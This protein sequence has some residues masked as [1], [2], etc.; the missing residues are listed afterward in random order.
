MSDDNFKEKI[1]D[2]FSAFIE[3][4]FD[5]NPF[6][7][8]D[9]ELAL[10]VFDNK[11]KVRLFDTYHRL[12][13]PI[14]GSQESLIYQ[15]M[16][17][18]T[19]NETKDIL[20]SIILDYDYYESCFRRLFQKFEGHACCVDKSRTIMQA[21]FRYYCFEKENKFDYS[22]Q[23]AYH[24]PVSILKDEMD[25]QRMFYA[26]YCVRYGDFDYYILTYAYLL[27]QFERDSSCS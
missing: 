26:F 15:K 17:T 21:L 4:R 11:Q 16:P 5:E 24:L 23:Y 20:A 27:K 14:R 18:E 9:V 2:I 10:S 22:Q 6:R 7:L 12:A 19:N 8:L 1:T 3:H 13:Y 25:A